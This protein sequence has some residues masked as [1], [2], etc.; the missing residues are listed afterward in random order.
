VVDDF[1]D[2]YGGKF[3]C[4]K[5]VYLWQQMLNW[6]GIFVFSLFARTPYITW[7][8]KGNYKRKRFLTIVFFFKEFSSLQVF[9]WKIFKDIK[10]ALFLSKFERLKDDKQ[11]NSINWLIQN[12]LCRERTSR[13]N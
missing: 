2:A 13:D 6:Q 3:S 8:V 12:L 4:A 11:G 10:L 5:R 9:L 7:K 1:L